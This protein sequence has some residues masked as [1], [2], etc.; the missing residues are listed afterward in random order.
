MGEVARAGV[1]ITEFSS[2][3]GRATA[4]ALVAELAPSGTCTF[5][6]TATALAGCNPG[7]PFGPAPLDVIGFPTAFYIHLD[8]VGECPL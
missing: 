3:I 6:I 7:D 5:D 2:G 4:I 8:V 1:L